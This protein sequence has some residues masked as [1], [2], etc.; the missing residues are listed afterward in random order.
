[1]HQLLLLAEAS[2]VVESAKARNGRQGL[3]AEPA[4]CSRAQV[5]ASHF[6]NVRLAPASS[7]NVA[8]GLQQGVEP[9][10]QQ[11]DRP[12]HCLWRTHTP[13]EAHPTTWR[14]DQDQM[15][16]ARAAAWIRDLLCSSARV[17]LSSVVRPAAA[18]VVPPADAVAGVAAARLAVAFLRLEILR[19]R[20]IGWQEIRPESFSFFL[21]NA[22]NV[23]IDDD[24]CGAPF[25]L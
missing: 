11:L 24:R 14:M 13:V 4:Q 17:R 15:L 10:K 23:R 21:L 1:M 9:P 7:L 18:A 22:V 19:R 16:I 2:R 12:S 25:V 5:G 8:D 6:A 20:I 3:C